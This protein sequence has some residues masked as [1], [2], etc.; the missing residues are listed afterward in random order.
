MDLQT[1]NIN[2]NKF[3]NNYDSLISDFLEEFDPDFIDL[4]EEQFDEGKDAI[5]NLLR[6]YRS[7]AYAAAK[8]AIGAKPAFGIPDLKLTGDFRGA[9]KSKRDNEEMTIYS[10][11]S[12]S[13][14]LQEK[15]GDIF[16]VNDDKLAKFVKEQILPSFIVYLNKKLFI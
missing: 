7:D 14:E 16:G 3:V 5:G 13:G 1:L 2:I 9:M 6:E 11:D 15:Y 10:T 12:K 8:K 4:N